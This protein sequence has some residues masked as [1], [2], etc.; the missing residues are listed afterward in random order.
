[1]YSPFREKNPTYQ[2]FLLYCID[3]KK[4]RS[5]LAPGLMM[6]RIYAFGLGV[7]VRFCPVRPSPFEGWMLCSTVCDGSF[8]IVGGS[9][10]IRLRMG[11]YVW[12]QWRLAWP[13]NK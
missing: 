5:T 6:W 7:Q 2:L 13:S 1:M 9:R 10:L 4:Q 8:L 12:G 3:F 11:D